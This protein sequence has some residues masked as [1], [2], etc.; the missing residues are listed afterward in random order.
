[1]GYEMVFDTKFVKL[2][3]GRLLHLIR[4]GCNNDTSG[5][6]LSDYR[7]KIYTKDELTERANSFMKDGQSTDNELKIYG[8]WRSYYDYGKHLLRM[9][10]R[11][12]SYNEFDS[13][14]YFTANRY[15]GVELFEPEEK[16]LTP[17]E[18]SKCFYDLL[19]GKERM[20][21]RRITTRLNSEAEIVEALDQGQHVSFYVGKTYKKRKSA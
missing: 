6:D 12:V 5:R 4:M 7:G 8:V 15:D 9:A 2:S 19:Y 18:F 10:K 17:E 1:M 20:S 11:A 21:Y 16:I 13:E 14:R 3:D